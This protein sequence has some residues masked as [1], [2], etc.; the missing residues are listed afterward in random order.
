MDDGWDVL[1][2]PSVVDSGWWR[3]GSSL[4]GPTTVLCTPGSFGVSGFHICPWA[5]VDPIG[6]TFLLSIVCRLIVVA[7]V[8]SCGCG[9]SSVSLQQLCVA[10]TVAGFP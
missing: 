7:I 8:L 3:L 6:L 9:S 2:I 5:Y 10:Y 1:D 4:Q